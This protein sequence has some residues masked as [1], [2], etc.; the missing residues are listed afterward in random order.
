MSAS[1]DLLKLKRILLVEGKDEKKICEKLA[2]DHGLKITAH[3]IDGRHKSR[4]FLTDLSVA[5]GF[6]ELTSIGLMLD[7]EEDEAACKQKMGDDEA[8]VR[9]K[10]FKGQWF[11]F[12]SPDNTTKGSL[13]TLLIRTIPLGSEVLKCANTFAECVVQSNESRLSTSAKLDTSVLLAYSSAV[14]GHPVSGIS[15][16]NFSFDTKHPALNEL[17]SFLRNFEE[18]Q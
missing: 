12:Q 10:G 15:N 13:E 9:S 8:F 6:N 1:I 17:V 4:R 5:T 16:H 18:Q 7:S 14:C 11:S 2:C 3:S